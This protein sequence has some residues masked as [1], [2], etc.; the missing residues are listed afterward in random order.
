[1]Q[2]GQENLMGI[3][4]H[5][6]CSTHIVQSI[7]N[8]SEIANRKTHLQF[9]NIYQRGGGGEAAVFGLS[10]ICIS[11]LIFEILTNGFQF[12]STLIYSCCALSKEVK[13]LEF[14]NF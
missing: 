4:L 12:L 13:K 9:E 1:M 11:S 6:T 10:I 7:C 8:I 3:F 5:Y 2:E 14:K